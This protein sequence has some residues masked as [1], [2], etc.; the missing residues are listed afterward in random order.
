MGRT[1]CAE[2]WCLY[3]GALMLLFFEGLE[4]W[5]ACWRW[6]QCILWNMGNELLSDVVLYPR[7]R[8]SL[9]T[10]LWKPL[11]FNIFPCFSLIFCYPGHPLTRIMHFVIDLTF[12]GFKLFPCLGHKSLVCA[13][14]VILNLWFEFTTMSWGCRSEAVIVQLDTAFSR[15]SMSVIVWKA[16]RSSRLDVGMF[17]TE[18]LLY[19]R[20]SW[21]LAAVWL[22]T[23]HC[24][25]KGHTT[26]SYFVLD[27]LTD[28]WT[29]SVLCCGM[30]LQFVFQV[31][32]V[33]SNKINM[34][35]Y[36]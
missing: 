29:E 8:E 14:F 15:L 11:R 6:R 22:V 23:I 27:L 12:L 10:P 1:A 21:M 16:H 3:K 31:F 5:V 36:I 18:N 7:S 17:V 19:G 30:V 13:P 28:E 25:G 4:V 2:P 20:E 26:L 33:L 32:I 24:T 34:Q 9:T 35:V